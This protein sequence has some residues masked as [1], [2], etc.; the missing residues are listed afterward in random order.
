LH[1]ALAYKLIG[2]DFHNSSTEEFFKKVLVVL[3]LDGWEKM[4]DCEVDVVVEDALVDKE[5]WSGPACLVSDG[6]S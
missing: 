5:P 4:G 1:F 2:Q 6:N 3:L